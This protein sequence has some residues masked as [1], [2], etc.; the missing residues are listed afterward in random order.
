MRPRNVMHLHEKRKESSR[1][2][3]AQKHMGGYINYC[4]ECLLGNKV[5]C[6]HGLSFS[7]CQEKRIYSAFWNEIKR[8]AKETHEAPVC[9]T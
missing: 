6:Q 5:K 7:R 9:N 1:L 8:R 3:A 2:G 4:F